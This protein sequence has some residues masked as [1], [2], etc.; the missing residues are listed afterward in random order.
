MTLVSRSTYLPPGSPAHRI[1]LDTFVYNGLDVSVDRDLWEVLDAQ[2]TPESS[3]LYNFTR[4]MA[5]P[6]L[7]MM[8]N[9]VK[10]DLQRRATLHAERSAKLARVVQVGAEISAVLFGTSINLASPVQ[11]AKI[12]FDVLGLPTQDR[13]TER[14][15]L[16]KLD[17]YLYAR[18]FINCVIE[19]RETKKDLEFLEA[20]LD[21]DGRLR[22][23]FNPVGTE[24][25]RW[26]SRTSAFGRGRNLQ[27][28]KKDL[29]SVIVADEG[30]VL[31]N[32]DL[33]QADA[34]V[35]AYISG[36]PDYIAAC[37]SGDL[38][39]TTAGMCFGFT[40][41]SPD[42]L[43][44]LAKRRF[45]R[46]FSYRD[47]TKR[48]GHLLNYLGNAYTMVQKLKLPLDVSKE[49]EYLYF[50]RFPLI[51]EVFQNGTIRTL[52]STKPPHLINPFGRKRVFLSSPWQ[53]KTHG[54][55]VAH[56]GQS[57][58][59]DACSV[60]IWKVWKHLG[61]EGVR[62]LLQV[63]DSGLF[64]V[65]REAL[66]KLAPLIRSTMEVPFEFLGKTR[67]IPVS[68][69]VGY[70]FD[71]YDLTPTDPTNPTSPPINADPN[72]LMSLKRFLE[73]HP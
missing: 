49:F 32:C 9:G 57:T 65:R 23:T 52:Q 51:R 55:A 58:T 15:E 2:R 66:A 31:V 38:H 45:Y 5:A 59:G 13:S 10:V 18:P 37:E 54:D 24:T 22:C 53:R 46:H 48:G 63:H 1:D 64:Q 47:T 39:S 56:L 3:L 33:E 19:Y 28:I 16:D 44:A 67:L 43:K 69:T 62:L 41:S 29:R 8:L 7:E 71:D 60:G 26:S 42:E 68:M 35:V 34:R 61:P 14:D 36:D 30:Y 4:A 72:S 17:A 25:G 6:A 27:N 12:L 11:V 21:E 20:E 40:G 73:L 70:N 50:K